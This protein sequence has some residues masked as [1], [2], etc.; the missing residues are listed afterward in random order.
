MI[1]VLICDDHQIVRQ[2]IRQILLDTGDIRPVAEAAN[3]PDAVA[4]AREGG[5]DVALL[6]IAMPQR[7]G[8]DVL[9][10]LKGEFP[11]LPVL[12]LSTYPDR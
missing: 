2:G 5:V 7:D 9:K 10:Q 4:R 12:V 1:R 8:L 11:R 3:G 6:D